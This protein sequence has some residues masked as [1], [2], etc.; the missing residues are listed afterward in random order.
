MTKVYN[1]SGA[2]IGWFNG[3]FVVDENGKK[4]YLVI[5]HDVFCVPRNDDESTLPNPP[6][7]GTG[8]FDDGIAVTDNGEIIFSLNRPGISPAVSA[9]ADSVKT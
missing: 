5:D 7:I 9:Q 2:D 6:C 3:L 4:L 8:E 1:Q